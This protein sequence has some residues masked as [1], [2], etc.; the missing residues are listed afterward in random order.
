MD[1]IDEKTVQIQLYKEAPEVLEVVEQTD[2]APK[3]LMFDS[4]RSNCRVTHQP[5]FGDV[6]IYYNS[7]KRID[8]ASLL[9]Y[10]VS[11]R[12]EYHFHEDM[13]FL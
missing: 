2:K 1:L 13:S 4:L 3:S 10:L 9:K 6:Y 12:S 8:E 7:Q 11:F 5:D